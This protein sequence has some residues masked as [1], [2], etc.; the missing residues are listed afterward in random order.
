MSQLQKSN[1]WCLE[2]SQEETGPDATNRFFFRKAL[3]SVTESQEVG[4]QPGIFIFFSPNYFE[5]CYPMTFWECNKKGCFSTLANKNIGHSVQFEF[6]IGKNLFLARVCPNCAT[7]HTH[8]LNLLVVYLQ[9]KSSCASCVSFGSFSWRGFY[10][11][12]PRD[13]RT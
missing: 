8:I 9:F 4:S 7:A 6:Q 12:L 1:Q 2:K 13:P 10:S 5:I 11:K 3:Y